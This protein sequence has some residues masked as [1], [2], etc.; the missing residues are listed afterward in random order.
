LM[1]EIRL[2]LSSAEKENTVDPRNVVIL[3]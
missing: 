2:P 1:V 3:S